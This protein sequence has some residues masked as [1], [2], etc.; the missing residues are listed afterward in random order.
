M[1]KNNFSVSVGIGAPSLMTIFL[2]LSLISFSVLSY[3]TARADF[4]F[5]QNFERRS[6]AYYE[7]SNFAELSI[8]MIRQKVAGTLTHTDDGSAF[9]TDTKHIL[10]QLVLDEEDRQAG[11]GEVRYFHYSVLDSSWTFAIRMLESQDLV[12]SVQVRYPSTSHNPE[13]VVTQWQVVQTKPWEPD[14]TLNISN[15]ND[16]FGN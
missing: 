7:T 12:V 3:M 8:A 13:F 6:N 1:K 15:T 16:F 2:I 14:M 4:R 11:I 9:T 10:D 5:T